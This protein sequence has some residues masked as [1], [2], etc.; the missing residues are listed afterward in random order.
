MA[1][2]FSTHSTSVDNE[3]NV[4][5]GWKD[6]PLSEL[7][8]AQARQLRT[9][10]ADLNIDFVCTSDLVRAVD[11][12]NIGIGDSLPKVFDKRL[13]EMNFGDYNGEP[14]EFIDRMKFKHIHTP[15]PNGES[16]VEALTRAHEFFNIL[17]IFHGNKNVLIVGHRATQQA[18]ETF[19]AR[20]P[21]EQ[22]LRAPFKWQPYWRYDWE[23]TEVRSAE[24]IRLHV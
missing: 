10:I 20:R 5:S 19:M 9:S 16:F 4:A 11:T 7:G 14:A 21:M 1:V 24:M 8:R 18:L 23:E 3:A 2:Y 12:V 15:F 22:V 17:K 6:A 13:R